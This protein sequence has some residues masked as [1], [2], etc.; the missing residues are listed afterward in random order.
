MYTSCEFLKNKYKQIMRDEPNREKLRSI[1]GFD[2]VG[3]FTPTLCSHSSLESS[4]YKKEKV[5]LGTFMDMYMPMYV[6]TPVNERNNIPVIA[7]HGHGSHGKEGLISPSG[8]HNYTYALEM[9]KRGY[10]VFV[11]DLCGSGE[12]LEEVS[13]LRGEGSSCNH[14]NNVC[15]SMGF[16]LQTLIVRELMGLIDYIEGQKLRTDKLLCIGFSGGGLSSVLL[17]ALDERVS[18][19]YTSGY[20]HSFGDT[21][22]K[23]NLC[24]CNFIPR[25]WESFDWGDIAALICPRELIVE[26]NDDDPLNE[27]PTGQIEITKRAYEKAGSECMHVLRGHGEHRFSGLG[28]DIIDEWSKK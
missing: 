6:L 10:T 27:N 2:K 23:N 12:R 13:K 16:S 25:L 7:L 15:M 8:K 24:G 22:L 5:I 28:F 1:M 9:V 18:L 11:P 17:S 19:C 14:I 21:I 20:F 4:H 26:Y 3:D